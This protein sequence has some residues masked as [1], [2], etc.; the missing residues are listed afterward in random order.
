M[1]DEQIR[2]IRGLLDLI[3]VFRAW[4]HT[5]YAVALAD[6]TYDLV[7]LWTEKYFPKSKTD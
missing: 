5:D 4:G 6:R 2:T 1:T 3:V 7:C